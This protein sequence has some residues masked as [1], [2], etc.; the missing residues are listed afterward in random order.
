MGDSGRRRS[1]TETAAILE[2]P[3][4]GGFDH[5]G[6]RPEGDRHEKSNDTGGGS[7]CEGETGDAQCE[8]HRAD[9]PPGSVGRANTEIAKR[10]LHAGRSGKLG[11]TG[12]DEHRAGGPVGGVEEG[13]GAEGTDTVHPARVRPANQVSRRWAI[14]PAGEFDPCSCHTRLRMFE[15]DMSTDPQTSENVHELGS[16]VLVA[17]TGGPARVPRRRP[18]PPAVVATA[19]AIVA[20]L[21]LWVVPSQSPFSPW[22]ATGADELEPIGATPVVLDLHDAT[23]SAGIPGRV[24]DSA[25]TS[26]PFG[27]AGG[28]PIELQPGDD[29]LLEFAPAGSTGSSTDAGSRGA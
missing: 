23:D 1:H 3:S 8:L 26:A 16:A 13:H 9:H 12:H 22:A 6:E 25:R 2:A 10:G 17:P 5:H 27:S 28:I 7:R 19:M 18:G 21:A 20:T 24:V 4:A 11:H 14:H 29:G 15:G